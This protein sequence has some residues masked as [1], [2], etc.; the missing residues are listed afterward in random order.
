MM[1]I[2]KNRKTALAVRRTECAVAI[3]VMR[4]GKLSIS[5][6]KHHVFQKEW[7]ELDGVLEHGISIFKD[8]AKKNGATLAAKRALIKFSKELEISSLRLF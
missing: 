8:H 1:V 5:Y 7:Q 6:V 3:I 2:N 4:S